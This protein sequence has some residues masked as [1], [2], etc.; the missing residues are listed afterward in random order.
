M[1][2]K[3]LGVKFREFQICMDRIIW[4]FEKFKKKVF[5]H[6]F[7]QLLHIHIYGIMLPARLFAFS[8]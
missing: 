1:L 6:K 3:Q 4:D 5:F 2:N 7:S 8:F